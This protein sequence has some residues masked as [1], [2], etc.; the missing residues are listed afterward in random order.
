[1]GSFALTASSG[2]VRITAGPGASFGIE[3]DQGS[4]ELRVG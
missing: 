4:G 1:M 2:N 3:S